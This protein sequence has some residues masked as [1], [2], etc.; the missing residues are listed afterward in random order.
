MTTSELPCSPAPADASRSKSPSFSS[1]IPANLNSFAPNQDFGPYT[2]IDQIAVGGMAEIYLAKTKGVAGFEKVLALKVIHPNYADDDQFIQ[3]LIDE[4]KISVGLSHTNICQIF[5]LGQVADTY[6]ISMEF[7]DGFDLFKIMRR[8]SEMN[9]DVPIESAVYIAQEICCG[10]DYA[11]RCKAP[12]GSPLSIVHRDI[13]PQNILLSKAGE[14]KIV[15]FGIAKAASRGRKTQAGVIKGKYFYMSPEQ[16][17]GD[18]IDHRTDIFSAGIILYEV[19]TG[20]MLYLEEDLHKLLDMVRKA[21]IPR[22]GTRRPGIPRQLE[23]IVMKALAKRP[24]DRFQTAHEFQSALTNF[25]YGHAP[26]FTPDR[27]SELVVDAMVDHADDLPPMDDPLPTEG[28]DVEILIDRNEVPVDHHSV[29]FDINQLMGGRGDDETTLDVDE[30]EDRGE[31]TRIS[32]PPEGM[33]AGLGGPYDQQGQAAAGPQLGFAGG[34]DTEA[35]LADDPTQINRLPEAERPRSREAHGSPGADPRATPAEIIVPR[36]VAMAPGVRLRGE[37]RGHHI[38]GTTPTPIADVGDLTDPDQLA[39][40]FRGAMATEFG[41][42]NADPRAVDKDRPTQPEV[43]VGGADVSS[44]AAAPLHLPPEPGEVDENAK[45]LGPQL[46]RPPSSPARPRRP[47]SRGMRPPSRGLPPVGRAPL[48]AAAPPPQSGRRGWDPPPPQRQPRLTGPMP[49]SRPAEQREDPTQAWETPVAQPAQVFAPPVDQPVDPWAQARQDADQRA[50]PEHLPPSSFAPPQ[51]HDAAPPVARPTPAQAQLRPQPR[52]PQAPPGQ[53]MP[54]APQPQPRPNVAFGAAPA[55]TPVAG[56]AP[57]LPPQPRPA[58]LAAAP[59]PGATSPAEPTPVAGGLQPLPSVFGRP[60]TFEQPR[61]RGL[62]LAIFGALVIVGAAIAVAA[63]VLWPVAGQQ[64]NIVVTSVPEGAT[65]FVDGK[66][67]ARLTP[68]RIPV[69]D[70][71]RS[72]RVK[73]ELKNHEPYEA[74]AQLSGDPPQVQIVAPL[75]PKTGTL[76]VTSK[77]SGAVL[78]IND[79]NRGTTPLVLKGLSLS[80]PTVFELRKRG[81]R[82]KT[83]PV[84]WGGQTYYKT[85]IQLEKLR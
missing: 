59:P 60:M 3:M 78:Y 48:P 41:E 51:T 13:S 21:D 39:P 85:T 37:Q 76:H 70:A 71:T 56:A 61:R 45:T 6:Y 31:S 15:D 54:A 50:A 5:D 10:L 49:H 68:V 29:I 69:S 42:L 55:A 23:T 19:L 80:T 66:R 83:H 24:S 46:I 38:P 25:L 84:K 9:I 73:V 18:P 17:W 67:I 57:Q 43:D 26:D 47:P 52:A 11:H 40:E 63:L 75:T 14:V 62:W 77:P 64:P 72:Y 1:T 81:Y 79:E 27:L 44:P 34:G 30:E 22:P 35:D 7:I 58:G 16:A 36:E 74:T 8:L 4:A 53:L 20:Q 82:T 65:V 33:F 32:G 28:A 12:D 2:L